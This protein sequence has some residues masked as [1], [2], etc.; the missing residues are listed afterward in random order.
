MTL[1]SH[2]FLGS[3]RAAQL[4]FPIVDLQFT[5]LAQVCAVAGVSPWRGF[6]QKPQEAAPVLVLDNNRTEWVDDR[7]AG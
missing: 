7:Q 5:S 6:A 1:K 3:R 4:I 2:V